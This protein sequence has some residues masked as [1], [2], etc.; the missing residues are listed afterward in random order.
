M[1]TFYLK[2]LGIELYCTD[3]LQNLK[4]T[5]FDIHLRHASIN[6]MDLFELLSLVRSSLLQKNKTNS[7]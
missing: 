3:S 6:K 4:L 7:A 2:V 5:E 1:N